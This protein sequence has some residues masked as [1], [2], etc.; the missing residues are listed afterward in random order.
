MMNVRDHND[1]QQRQARGLSR[2]CAMTRF[3]L[4]EKYAA[5]DI[6]RI[7]KISSSSNRSSRAM[8]R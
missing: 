7:D 1:A 6:P 3:K 5:P 4:V 2:T 8:L